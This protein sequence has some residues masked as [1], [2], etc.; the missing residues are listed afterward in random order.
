MVSFNLG[1]PD[2][3]GRAPAFRRRRPVTESL[4]QLQRERRSLPILTEVGDDDD[5]GLVAPASRDECRS[6]IRPCPWVSCR[7]HLYLDVNP[8]TGSLKLNF[9]DREPHE[10]SCSCAL[11]VAEDGG[12]TLEDVGALLNLTRERAR[13]LEAMALRKVHDGLQK[14]SDHGSDDGHDA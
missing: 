2:A 11:D 5:D 6:G 13:Q 9:P 4:R 1:R 7:F 14:R 8:R 10:L 3:G 12:L